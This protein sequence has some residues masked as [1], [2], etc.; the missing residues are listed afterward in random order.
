MLNRETNVRNYILKIS[1]L[2]ADFLI[3]RKKE[4]FS[5]LI[6]VLVFSRLLDAT[7]NAWDKHFEIASARARNYLSFSSHQTWRT[8]DIISLGEIKCRNH[9]KIKL[10]WKSEISGQNHSFICLV[11]ELFFNLSTRLR[12]RTDSHTS[13]IRLP[14]KRNS[15]FFSGQL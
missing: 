14:A 6:S 7:V 15:F 10:C 3:R 11:S 5:T 13:F 4:M 9:V 1:S 12:W 8:S 2:T